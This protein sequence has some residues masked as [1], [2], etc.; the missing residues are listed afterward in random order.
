[1]TSSTVTLPAGQRVT[2]VE[3]TITDDSEVEPD[4]CFRL[5]IVSM[6]NADFEPGF[7]EHVSISIVDDDELPG[8]S[9]ADAE[10]RETAG[11]MAFTVT[12]SRVSSTEVTV[13]Y[14]TADGTAV[15]SGD[16]TETSGTLTFEPGQV[17][18]VV[19]VPIFYDGVSE[20]DETFSLRLSNAS[21]AEIVDGDA[22]AAI[23]DD[24]DVPEISVV[25][26]SIGENTLVSGALV[27]LDSEITQPVSFKVKLVEMSSLGDRAATLSGSLDVV[28]AALWGESFT[29]NPGGYLFYPRVW[30]YDDQIPE[31]DEQFLVVITDVVGATV[32]SA[33]A[34]VTIIDDDVPIVSLADASVSESDGS[35]VFTLDL[36]EP[37][38][39]AT[40]LRYTTAVKGSAGDG[41]AVPAE[42]YI[43]TAGVLGIAAGEAAAT[44]VVPIIG[45]SHDELDETFLLILSDPELLEL[46]DSGAVGT[47]VDDDPGW[48]I[49]DQDVWEYAG[50]MVFN[51]VRDHTSDDPVTLNYQIAAAGSAVGGASCTDGVDYIEPSGSVTLQATDTTATIS[52]TLCDDVDIEGRETLLVELTGVPGRKLTGVGTITSD[53]S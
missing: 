32:G 49:D 44:V 11:S 10:A 16:Y 17:T 30:I 19:E 36:N 22:E 5:A 26:F 51:V 43:H 46:G 25:G 23:L 29:L 42:D 3:V 24:T 18:A 7:G 2:S 9:V 40:S 52:I 39:Y 31:L 20:S 48:T 13:S 1:M 27:E 53:D 21:G 8:L 6:T 35:M 15:Q 47:I 38:P 14:A 45:D 4:E 34:T 12:L 33:R 28:D 41:A 50:T 37:S